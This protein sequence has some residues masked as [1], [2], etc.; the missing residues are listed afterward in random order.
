MQLYEDSEI[1]AMTDEDEDEVIGADKD[2]TEADSQVLL[3]L[4]SLICLGYAF[5]RLRKP[6]GFENV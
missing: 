3:Y 2:A 4:I 1:E 6:G 5:T